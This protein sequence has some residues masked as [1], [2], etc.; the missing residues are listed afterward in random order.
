LPNGSE[1]FAIEALNPVVDGGV[2]GVR[3][4]KSLVR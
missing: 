4:G 3:I 1:P 2:E